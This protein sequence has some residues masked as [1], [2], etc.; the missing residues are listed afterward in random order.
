MRPPLAPRLAV[1]TFR[2][3]VEASLP[4]PFSLQEP[5]ALICSCVSSPHL[6]SCPLQLWPQS[7]SPLPDALPKVDGQCG[8]SADAGLESPPRVFAGAPAPPQSSTPPLFT[9]D[10]TLNVPDPPQQEYLGQKPRLSCPHLH[11][12]GPVP[13]HPHRAQCRGQV[14]PASPF[15]PLASASVHPLTMGTLSPALHLPALGG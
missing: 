3:I 15:P 12:P 1:S 6:L 13:R 11:P 7:A 14:D 9:V 2:T 5:V 10:E 8:P 4:R